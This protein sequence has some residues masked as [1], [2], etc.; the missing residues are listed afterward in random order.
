MTTV[1]LWWS[2]SFWLRLPTVHPRIQMVLASVRSLEAPILSTNKR[3]VGGEFDEVHY[4]AVLF[5]EAAPGFRRKGTQYMSRLCCLCGILLSLQELAG[6]LIAVWHCVWNS[7][8]RE[9][10]LC[11]AVC[12]FLEICLC[13]SVYCVFQKRWKFHLPY[14]HK[15]FMIT[16]KAYVYPRATHHESFLSS[17][18]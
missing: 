3:C 14:W 17:D 6:S 18:S 11:S 15:P 10:P 8:C 7:F 5:S 13:F 1:K 16:I 9:L 2:F 4:A 12:L